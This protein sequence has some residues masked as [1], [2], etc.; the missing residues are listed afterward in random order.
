MAERTPT[1]V[2]V[3]LLVAIV[4]IAVGFGA[5][6]GA[7][8]YHQ[9]HDTAAPVP[10]TTAPPSTTVPAV[11]APVAS[12]TASPAA[13]AATTPAPVPVAGVVSATF[14]PALAAAALGG[15]VHASV[16]DA[17][18]GASLF[19]A[20]SALASAPASTN[21]LLT[22]SAAL[23]VL[24]GTTRFV[25][26][27]VA[28][29]TAGQIVIIGGGDPTLSAATVGQPTL[30]AGAARLSDLAAQV[31]G[32]EVRAATTAPVTSIVVDDS[33]YSG[34]D[35]APS[36]QPDDVPSNY[37]SAITALVVDGGRPAGGGEIRSA[38]PD[39]EAGQALANLLGVPTAA[40][41]RGTAPVGAL[42]LGT[43]QS[44]PMI[45]IIEQLLSESDNTLAEMIARQ[46]AIAEH[47]PASFAGAVIGVR[48]ALAAVGVT[49]APTLFDGSGLSANDRI[50]PS[51]LVA[52]LRTALLGT[53]PAL[54]QLVSALPVAGW[55]G[56]LATRYQVPPSAAAAGVVRAKTG[57]LTGVVT[58]AGILRDA[59]GRVLLFAV[60]TDHVPADG[61]AA[62]EAAL[63]VAVT[64]LAAC[65]C[66]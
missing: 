4:A 6:F 63:D 64:R 13:P 25:T 2:V 30:Y 8:S 49:I 27:V 5:F 19:N 12:A 61:T 1:R 44:A 35:V 50:S 42:T 51:E 45:D 58:L 54:A 17:D 57:T 32:A 41:T 38:T 7:H 24:P 37:G 3:V 59:S 11:P 20:G 26:R 40:V 52:V 66:R 14:A 9:H 47:Q 15:T 34:P 16:I 55:E 31:K 29:V 39:L 23:S 21:K 65:G 22:C 43:V 60:M 53:H 48:R 33:L 18:T 46:V 10:T 36:W 56:T 62:A 28:G